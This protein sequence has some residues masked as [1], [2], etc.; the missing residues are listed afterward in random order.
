MRRLVALTVLA[1]GLAVPAAGFA[2]GGGDGDGTLS[3]KN[4]LGK[5][6][7][8]FTGSAV[9]RIGYGSIRAS[10]PV[11]GDGSGFVVWNCDQ[12]DTKFTTTIC[13]GDNIRFRAIGGR[14]VL[15][16]SG[17]GV[18]LSVVGHGNAILNGRGEVPDVPHDGV[19]S[20]NE[21]P[22]KSLPDYEKSILLAAPAGS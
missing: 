15:R 8:D 13:S 6:R 16:I 5:V 14:Y 2:L 9:G 12:R 1:F 4:G 21:G 19:Y 22:Y 10:D 7:L 3:V 18:F 20:L 17:S 11:F